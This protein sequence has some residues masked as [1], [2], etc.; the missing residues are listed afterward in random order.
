M[1]GLVH[2]DEEYIAH[3]DEQHVAHSDEQFMY[4]VIF[5]IYHLEAMSLTFNPTVLKVSFR[6]FSQNLRE[7]L[8]LNSITM[9]SID[10]KFPIYGEL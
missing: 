2:M 4:T 9:D 6:S 1:M 3:I 10:K 8:V 5:I 7:I